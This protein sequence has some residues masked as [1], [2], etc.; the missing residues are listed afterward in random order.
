MKLSTEDV[1]N[2]MQSCFGNFSNDQ[3][4]TMLEYL[5][6]HCDGPM[7]GFDVE[8]TVLDGFYDDATGY[9]S[10]NLVLKVDAGETAID[11]SVCLEQLRKICQRD[12]S[13][14]FEDIIVITHELSD[15]EMSVALRRAFESISGYQI[16]QLL[17]ALATSWKDFNLIKRIADLKLEVNRDFVDYEPVFECR[18][19]LDIEY[20]F[21]HDISN[22]DLFESAEKL[23]SLCRW[24]DNKPLPFFKHVFIDLSVHLVNRHKN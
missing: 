9:Y 19:K 16:G 13:C 1:N 6:P 20:L 24:I 17:N 22:L 12:G 23:M 3:I 18:M 21:A 2:L 14:F 7:H 11:S 8:A 5:C 10:H 4:E 15:E